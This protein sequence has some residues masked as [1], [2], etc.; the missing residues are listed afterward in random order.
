MNKVVKKYAEIDKKTFMTIDEAVELSDELAKRAIQ[1]GVQFEEVVGIANGA[2]L[3]TVIIAERL[4]LPY[5]MLTIRRKWSVFNSYLARFPF[6]VRFFSIWYSV[7][8]LNYPLISVIGKMNTL[9][10]NNQNEN[11]ECFKERKNILIVDDAIQCGNTIQAAQKI[12]RSGNEE[13]NL[14]VAVISWAILVSN[15]KQVATP[16]I[17]INRKIQHFPWSVNSPCYKQ[18]QDWLKKHDQG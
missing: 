16:D 14:K 12:I 2:R 13:C 15:E 9:S 3:P 8:I 1:T 18:Y 11:K 10:D 4:G 7:P 6:I 17:Y 5:K